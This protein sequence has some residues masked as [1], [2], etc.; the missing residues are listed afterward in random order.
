MSDKKDT[1][2][3]LFTEFEEVVSLARV[4]KTHKLEMGKAFRKLFPASGKTKHDVS[5][6]LGVNGST[7]D[8]WFY[9][10]SIPHPTSVDSLRAFFNG[11]IINQGSLDISLLD[12]LC[13]VEYLP[14]FEIA[15]EFYKDHKKVIDKNSLEDL[16][17]FMKNSKGVLT[18]ELMSIFLG[19]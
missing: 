4:D 15:I 6:F 7:V 19:L 12:S 8:R 5:A 3:E 18:K 9:G 10:K 13:C 14:L 1:L 17:R 2:L 16:L 11:Q